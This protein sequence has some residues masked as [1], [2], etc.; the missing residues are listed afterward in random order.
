MGQKVS[1]EAINTYIYAINVNSD[2]DTWSMFSYSKI[3][4][5]KIDNYRFYYVAIE[6]L[7]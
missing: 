5:I 6:I 7:K 1:C 4:F 3:E 2:K